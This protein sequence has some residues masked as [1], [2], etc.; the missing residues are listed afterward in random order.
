GTMATP[1]A[2][3]NPR[4]NFG[5][6]IPRP[7]ITSPSREWFGDVML[8]GFLL[9]QCFDGIFTYVGVVTFGVAIEA[10]PF[11][12]WLMVHFRNGGAGIGAKTGFGFLGLSLPLYGIHWGV[13]VL[14]GF[15]LTGPIL[16]WVVILFF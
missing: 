5:S 11:L 14:A 4:A 3:A 9:A 15:F 8:L 1:A 10:N 13:A 2:Y 7:R 16:P 6:A 12:S